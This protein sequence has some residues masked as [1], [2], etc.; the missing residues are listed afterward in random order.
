[1]RLLGVVLLLVGVPPLIG[2]VIAASE[3]P[4]YEARSELIYDR[5]TSSNATDELQIR[6]EVALISSRPV[7]ERASSTIGLNVDE[8]SQIVSASR[9]SDSQIIGVAA[10]NEDGD[11]AVR[12]VDAVVASYLETQADSPDGAAETAYLTERIAALQEQL[13]AVEQRVAEVAPE[14]SGAADSVTLLTLQSQAEALR[15]QITDAQS[16]ITNLTVEGIGS[17]SPVRLLTPAYL[18]DEPISPRPLRTVVGG[19]LAGILLAVGFLI[20]RAYAARQGS[21]GRVV[22]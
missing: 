15:T 9:I 6:T 20:A 11:S 18:A 7:L 21:D 2:G 8:L 13:A 17:G 12:V 3:D 16:Q 14:G 10:T 4:V 1:M 5:L 22:E 19:L